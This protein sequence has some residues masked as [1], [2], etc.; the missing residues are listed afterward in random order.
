MERLIKI[1][2][3]D[4]DQLDHVEVLRTLNKRN[5]LYKVKTAFNGEHALR[6]LTNTEPNEEF[7]G[8]PDLIILD[9]GMPRMNGMELLKKIRSQPEWKNIKVF[10]LTSSADEKQQIAV[11][12]LGVSGYIVKPL[13]LISPHSGDAFNLMIDLMNM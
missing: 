9:L 6:L 3:V 4:D 11:R 2:L 1:L 10:V 5:I 7:V 13:K 8:T 12:E